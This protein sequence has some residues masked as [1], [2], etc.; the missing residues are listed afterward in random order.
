MQGQAHSHI[1][2]CR[3]T[4]TH[5]HAGPYPQ[6]HTHV[7]AGTLTYTPM[8]GHIDLGGHTHAGPYPQAHTHAEAGTLACTH[9]CRGTLTH[10]RAGAHPHMRTRVLSL[11]SHLPVLGPSV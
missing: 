4:L 10:T 5:T 7:G 1:H 8:Q 6:A 11:H 2:S 3:G 9:S